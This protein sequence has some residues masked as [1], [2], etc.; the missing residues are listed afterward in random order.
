[1]AI[2]NTPATTNSMTSAASTAA[3]MPAMPP[4]ISRMGLAASLR[5]FA[6]NPARL[7]ASRLARRLHL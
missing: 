6:L 5:E 7:Y 3:V 2:D 1:V 4:P